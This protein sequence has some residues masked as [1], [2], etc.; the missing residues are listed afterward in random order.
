[1][2]EIRHTL[3]LGL[4]GVWLVCTRS[5]TAGPLSAP[6]TKGT[7]LVR[8]E[9]VATGLTAPV[10]GSHAPGDDRHLFLADQDGRLWRIDLD[11]EE[12]VVFLDL[13]AR[14]VSLGLAGPGSFDERGFLGFAFHPDYASNGL[15]YTYT[16][17]PGRAPA[18]LDSL[19]PALSA[20]HQSVITKWQ[21]PDPRVS[22]S[23][24]DPRSARE[25]L[26][27]DQPHAN[28]NAG[29][30]AFGPDGYLYIA[31]GDGGGADDPHGNGQNPRTPLGALLRIDPLGSNSANGQY[32]IPADNPFVGDASA[33]DEIFAYG[34]R[35]PFRFSFDSSTGELWLGDVGQNDIEEVDRIS[36]GGNYGWSTKEGSYLFDP[37]GSA[38]GLVTEQAQVPGL[39]D[40]VAEYDHDEGSAVIGGFVHRGA[41]MPSLQGRYLFGDSFHAASGGGRLFYLDGGV[42]RELLIEGRDT[43]GLVLLGFGQDAAG[44]LYVLAN[45]GGTPFGETGVALRLS[46]PLSYSLES[47]SLAVSGIRVTV[48][49]GD[50]FFSAELRR[51]ANARRLTLE[52]AHARQIPGPL[53][54]GSPFGDD[55]SGVFTLPRVEVI[56]G[57]GDVRAYSASLRRVPG[58]VPLRVEVVDAQPLAQ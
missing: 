52:L 6:I 58:P 13:R 57:P 5:A 39:I 8:L 47:G 55:T 56:F 38:R 22:T 2:T 7:V 45:G 24:A 21:V 15:L 42:I 1:M 28:H 25:V 3:L 26:R 30:V 33:L 14:L 44:E 43:L 32:G 50:L 46:Q 19:P 48:P 51:V 36:V 23:R 18:D 54:E 31:L 29:A 12:K 11:T 4:L 27:I 49:T 34:F 9:P 17:E 40:P 35:N 20:N 41:G 37:N 53:P 16:S 10:W